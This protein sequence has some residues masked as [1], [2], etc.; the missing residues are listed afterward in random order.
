MKVGYLK[1]FLMEFNDEDDVEIVLHLK[2]DEEHKF[3]NSL[4]VETDYDFNPPATIHIKENDDYEINLCKYMEENLT[5]GM[6][7]PIMDIMLKDKDIIEMSASFEKFLI[8]HYNDVEVDRVIQEYN[9]PFEKLIDEFKNSDEYDEFIYDFTPIEC[10]MYELSKMPSKEKLIELKKKIPNVNV[11]KIKDKIGFCINDA[12]KDFTDM[13]EYAYLIVGEDFPAIAK[14]RTSLS[15]K[16]WEDLKRM[17]GE[18][19]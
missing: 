14:D 5:N 8:K 2:N 15:E 6:C 17:R 4:W 18:E 16:A 3:K 12:R 7:F 11:V 1:E 10:K 19:K 9:V 13:V